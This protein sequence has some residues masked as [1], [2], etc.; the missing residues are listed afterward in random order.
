MY[1]THLVMIKRQMAKKSSNGFQLVCGIDQ[2]IITRQGCIFTYIESLCR[3]T[4]GLVVYIQIAAV[5]SKFDI[6]N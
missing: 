2:N 4:K 1:Q 3:E 6:Q 5:H